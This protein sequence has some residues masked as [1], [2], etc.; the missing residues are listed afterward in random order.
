MYVGHESLLPHKIEN[1]GRD[2][3]IRHLTTKRLLLADLW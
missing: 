3:G 2:S 1:K